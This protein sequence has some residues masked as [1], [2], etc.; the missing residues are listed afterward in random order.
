MP[1]E[2]D[3]IRE[4][5]LRGGV[6]P[7]RAGRYVAELQ[8]HFEDLVAEEEVAGRSSAEAR[9]QASARLGSADA[10]VGA[11]VSRPEF[12]ALGARAPATFYLVAPILLLALSIAGFVGLVVIF[13][14]TLRPD[15]AGASDL[16]AWAV[17][18]L[19]KAVP[20]A[21]FGLTLLLGWILA[22]AA[23][24]Q[25]SAPFWPVCG[26]VALAAIGAALQ[27]EVTPPMAGL[28]GEIDLAPGFDLPV[29][30]PGAFGTRLAV[31]LNHLLPRG[32]ETTA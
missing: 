8:D 1:R 13:C 4:Q 14:T 16:P 30:S 31:Y 2:L 27:V 23:I 10:L 28:P 21:N 11:M 12:Q 26:I 18:V 19:A 6:R 5:L 15:P 9:R 32:D 7:A 24:R 17:T 25:R 22:A 20:A 29:F 3:A